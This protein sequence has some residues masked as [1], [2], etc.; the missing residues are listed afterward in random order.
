MVGSGLYNGM[1]YPI[2]DWK[3]R[4]ANLVPRREQCRTG[5]GIRAVAEIP[6]SGLARIMADAGHAFS[7]GAV[8][9]LYEEARPSYG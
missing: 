2:R 6:D 3:V 4:G 9:Q 7:L 8:A 5:R 1:I